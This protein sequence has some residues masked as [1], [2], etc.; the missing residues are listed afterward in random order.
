MRLMGNILSYRWHNVH[1]QVHDWKVKKHCNLG[2][3]INFN[4][5]CDSIP[6]KINLAYQL[7]KTKLPVILFEFQL[8]QIK[9]DKK[10][11]KNNWTNSNSIRDLNPRFLNKTF[12]P[13]VWILR[14]IRSIELTVLKKSRLYST[15]QRDFN[16]LITR[17]FSVKSRFFKN[18]ELYWSNLPQNSNLGQ[19]SFVQKSVVRI[20]VGE[21]HENEKKTGQKRLTFPDWDLNPGSLNNFLPQNLNLREIRSIELKVLKKSWL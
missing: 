20:P 15:S 5:I 3:D 17:L 7:C 14:E 11:G 10:V 16:T 1:E 18:R 9:F 6:L 13:K 12:P 2:K 19:E 21:G 4:M 8:C